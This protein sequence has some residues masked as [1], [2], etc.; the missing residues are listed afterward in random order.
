MD[1]QWADHLFRSLAD[2]SRRDVVRLVGEAPLM[3]GEIAEVL[4]LPQST[5]SRHLKMLRTTGLLV[6]RRQ[7][8]RIYIGLVEP[9]LNGDGELGDMLNGWLRRQPLS[10]PVE[11]RLQKVLQGRNG[12]EDAFERL[13][14]QWDELRCQH[15]GGLFHLESLASLLPSEWRVLDIGT[16]TGY[17]LPF[18]CRHF[19][20]VI[21]VDPSPAMLALARQRAEREG[22]SNVRFRSGRLED[23][24]V[25]EASIDAALAILALHHCGDW[26]ASM[27]ELRRVLLPG[28]RLLAV[29]ICP[30]Q[31]SDFKREM[32]DPSAGIDPDE[33]AQEMH[34]AGFEILLKRKLPLPP[35]DHPAA[36][37]RSAPDLFVITASKP[38]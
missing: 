38:E 10:A 36:P 31:L 13:A 26:T 1:M 24:P 5:V 25:R 11:A 22:L 4:A 8:N 7:G 12:Q 19:R 28:G 20:E 17:L 14:H 9:S 15:F 2:R 18:L 29:D 35:G 3:V 27:Q 37:A 21:A 6:D 34:R 30:H 33:L 16:G 32:G 23:L